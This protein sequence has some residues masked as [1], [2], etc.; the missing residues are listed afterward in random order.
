MLTKIK[1]YLNM[2][3]GQLDQC[4]QRSLMMQ[5]QKKVCVSILCPQHFFT[6]STQ[7]HLIIVRYLSEWH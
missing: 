5:I 7:T 6:L 3:M 2:I 1:T 4:V